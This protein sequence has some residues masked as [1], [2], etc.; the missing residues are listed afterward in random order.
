MRD[1][2]PFRRRRSALTPGELIRDFFGRD[3]LEEFFDTGF[4]TGFGS[5]MAGIRADIKET[6]KEY[7]VDTEMPGFAKEDIEIEQMDDWRT[8][9]GKRNQSVNEDRSN[10]IRRERRYDQVSRTFLLDGVK[11]EAVTADYKNGILRIVLPKAEDYTKRR[12]RI[13]IN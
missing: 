4:L 10:F 7:I 11:Q 8:F 13:D 9:T 6:D 5:G 1:I 3:L 12:R 2:T